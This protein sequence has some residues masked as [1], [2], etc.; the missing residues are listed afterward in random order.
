M[1][2]QL[3]FLAASAAICQADLSLLKPVL[4]TMAERFTTRVTAVNNLHAGALAAD[5]TNFDIWPLCCDTT[6]LTEVFNNNY[7][8]VVD[9]A[10]A[11]IRGPC[12]HGVLDTNRTAAMPSVLGG[13]PV[14]GNSVLGQAFYDACDKNT[15]DYD[16]TARQYFGAETGLFNMFPGGG[17][18]YH[19][20]DR[21]SKD[22]YDCRV[23]PWYLES[24]NA[25]ETDKEDSVQFSPP[26]IG[27]VGRV[28]MVTASKSV[29]SVADKIFQGVVG[30]DMDMTFLME[31]LAGIDAKE[32]S[33][34]FVV[35]GSNGQII[36][37]P[38]LNDVPNFIENGKNKVK[39]AD[40]EPE[41]A[42]QDKITEMLGKESAE[43]TLDLVRYK[44]FRNSILDSED[45]ESAAGFWS[46]GWMKENVQISC[47]N[48]ETSG[49][50]IKYTICAAK[51]AGN[52]QWH[53]VLP[54]V[55]VLALAAG[56]FVMKDKLGDGNQV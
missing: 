11:C 41:K 35:D 42:V 50:S 10:V 14:C 9:M 30:I 19:C 7:G 5:T 45:A 8:C 28:L 26:Y 52:M 51:T 38:N 48:L 1:K 53:F 23:R 25:L 46:T 49:A 20:D 22:T 47:V 29:I 55:I 24:K 43:F 37:H 15:K 44:T 40:V 39:V 32:D 12:T 31:P 17:V 18:G 36:A 33:Y 56:L 27:H 16:G 6:R 34:S 3:A 13:T 2:L 4:T 21:V 54:V